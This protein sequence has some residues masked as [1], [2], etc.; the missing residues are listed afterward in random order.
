[1]GV[2]GGFDY[3]FNLQVDLYPPQPPHSLGFL[4]DFKD[5]KG[6]FDYESHL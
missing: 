1:M 4:V 6:V 2:N 3:S 5:L